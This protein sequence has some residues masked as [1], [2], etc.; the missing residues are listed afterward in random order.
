MRQTIPQFKTVHGPAQKS[1]KDGDNLNRAIALSIAAHVAVVLVFVL[2]MVIYPNEPLVLENT[3][4]V[5]LVALPD[6]SPKISSVPAVETKIPPPSPP[7]PE[8]EAAPV[9]PPKPEVV[10]PQPVKTAPVKPDSPK[11][12]L[13][14]T[15]SVQDAALKRLEALDKLERMSKAQPRSAPAPQPIKGNQ[16]SRGGSLSGVVRLEQQ[17]YLQTID[18]AVKSHWNL[19]GF[20]SS[21]NLS[22]RARLF[23]DSKGVVVKRSITQSSRNDIFDQRV[24]AAID[25]AS[26]LPAPP[27]TLTSILEADGIELEFVPQ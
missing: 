20:L 7:P 15:K 4:R 12:N 26:P 8:P 9:E 1:A 27:S 21:A 13:N 3:M 23:I 18:G 22:A 10:A 19:P 14:K 5:D 17:G 25:A 16:I 2:K 24:L 6:K 11:V